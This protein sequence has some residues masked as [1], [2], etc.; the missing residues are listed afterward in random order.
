MPA[1]Q[2]RWSYVRRNAYNMLSERLVCLLCTFRE[3]LVQIKL[4]RID[5]KMHFA[6]IRLIIQ[7]RTKKCLNSSI[8]FF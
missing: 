7:R 8:L 1:M 5:Q 2:P 3:F 4:L 6:F